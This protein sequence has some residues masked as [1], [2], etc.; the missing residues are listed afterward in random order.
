[1][2]KTSKEGIVIVGKKKTLEATH[3]RRNQNVLQV[4]EWI[5]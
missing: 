1:M 5:V 4:S 3:R 2:R